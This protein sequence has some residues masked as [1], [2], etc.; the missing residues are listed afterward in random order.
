MLQRLAG[1]LSARKSGEVEFN[2]D[3]S[4]RDLELFS[5][6]ADGEGGGDLL[7]LAVEKDGDGRLGHRQEYRAEIV[8]PQ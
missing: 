8:T 4:G 5:E 6:L 7:R 2:Q 1:P 3:L